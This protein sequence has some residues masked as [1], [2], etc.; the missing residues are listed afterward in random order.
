MNIYTAGKGMR[1]V[2]LSATLFF[3]FSGYAFSQCNP[4]W[5]DS[6]FVYPFTDSFPCI[7]KGVPYT[8]SFQ[9]N[10]PNLFH[11]L[12]NLD[13]LFV[14][15]ITGLPPGITWTSSPFP[16]T[17]E[18]DSSGC[19]TLSGTETTYPLSQDTAVEFYFNFYCHAVVTTQSAGTQNLTYSQLLQIGDAPIP[20]FNITVIDSGDT[21]H[22]NTY[23]NYTGVNNLSAATFIGVYPNPLLSGDS[24]RVQVNPEMIGAEAELFDADGRLVFSTIIRSPQFEITPDNA[25]GLYLLRI[26]S[27]GFSISKKL[28]KQ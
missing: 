19:V 4:A 15:S 5:V 18:A 28:L 10:A 14:D 11:G 1:K 3:A 21:C 2:F 24:W 25:P 9:I 27:A 26:H 23:P 16:L 20:T 13:T 6:G 7:E 8:G 12:I 17:L 22:P